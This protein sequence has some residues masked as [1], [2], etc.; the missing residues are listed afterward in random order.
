MCS[1]PSF[2]QPRAAGD[3]QKEKVGLVVLKVKEGRS[4]A[5]EVAGAEGWL[6]PGIG[7]GFLGGSMVKNLLAN[8]G[9][10][11]SIPGTGRSPGGE[12]GNPLLYSCLENPMDRGACPWGCKRVGHNLTTKQQQCKLYSI[13]GKLLKIRATHSSTVVPRTEEP[14]G[15]QS[16]G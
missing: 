5:P 15:L 1:L 12:N 8:A 3:P 4:W 6:G 16:M 2:T 10:T 11:G 14:G 13:M 7:R 9:D